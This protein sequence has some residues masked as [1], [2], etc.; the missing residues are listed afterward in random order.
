MNS[1]F[2]KNNASE[3]VQEAFYSLKSLV[4]TCIIENKVYSFL[5]LLHKYKSRFVK[6]QYF[7]VEF[8]TLRNVNETSYINDVYTTLQYEL[9]P[10]I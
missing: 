5:M 10:L 1:N 4:Y 9:F 2:G 7:F 3:M 8:V 6:C